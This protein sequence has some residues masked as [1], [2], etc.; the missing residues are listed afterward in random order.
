MSEDNVKPSG[1]AIFFQESTQKLWEKVPK[2]YR[3]IEMM[4][5]NFLTGVKNHTVLLKTMC[6]TATK[7]HRALAILIAQQTQFTSFTMIKL[8]YMLL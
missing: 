6:N 8:L 7:F 4:Y 5:F 1:V 2:K 3:E